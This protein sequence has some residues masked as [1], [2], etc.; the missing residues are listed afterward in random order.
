MGRPRLIP[1]ESI[2]AAAREVFLARGSAATV[3][4]VARRVG[5]SQA[6]V[7]KRFPTK[8]ELFLAA[9]ASGAGADGSAGGG[10]SA[11]ARSIGDRKELVDRFRRRA[12]AAGVRR[13]LVELGD[14]LL[15]FFRQVLPLLLLSWSNRGEFGFPQA[16][17]QAAYPPTQ[18]AHDVVAFFEGEMRARRLRRHDPWLVTRAFVGGLQNYVLLELFSKGAV[19]MVPKQAPREY[20][21]GLVDVL[22]RGI[23]PARKHA[24]APARKTR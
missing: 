16:M 11:E 8:Q 6:A 20:V 10:R 18:A 23:A 4:E 15:P 9:M 1:D 21:R 14:E 19:P 12:R 7:F 22:W 2:L 13:A 24:V 3:V 17:T 5:L